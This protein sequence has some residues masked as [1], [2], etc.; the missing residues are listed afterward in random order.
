M[1]VMFQVGVFRVLMQCNV[2]VGC[3]CSRGPVWY[4]GSVDLWYVGNV[5]QHTTRCHNPDD[6]D[7]K[8]YEWILCGTVFPFSA[9]VFILQRFRII[10]H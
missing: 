1:A 7:L 3:Q 5:P 6:H 9:V 8:N 10:V 4:G 2:A